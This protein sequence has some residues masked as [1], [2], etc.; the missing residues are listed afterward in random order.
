MYYCEG[1]LV[2]KKNLFKNPVPS[3]C[4]GGTVFFVS[5][6]VGYTEA[7]TFYLQSFESF[8]TGYPQYAELLQGARVP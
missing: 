1:I 8:T 7:N 4:G 6:N 2:V 5:W 3:V